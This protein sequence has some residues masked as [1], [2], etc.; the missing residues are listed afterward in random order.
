MFKHIFCM[1][2]LT[3]FSINA[4]AF[5]ITTFKSE[6]LDRN[7]RTHILVTGVGED[8]GNQ[9]Q[10]VAT[11]KAL[12]YL[13]NFPTDQIVLITPDE[14]DLD[15][16]PALANWGFKVQDTN[17]RSFDGGTLLDELMKFNAIASLDIFS[18]S[19]AQYGIHLDGKLH[20]FTNNTKGIDKLKSHF[21]SDAFTFLHGCNAGFNFAPMLASSWQIPVAGA[22]TSTNFHKLHENGSFY[23][24]EKEFKP[25]G[26]W[27]KSNNLS[28]DV[29]VTCSKGGCQRLKPD[30]QP[31]IGFWGEYHDGGLPFYKFFCKDI[32]E[33]KCLLGMANS[34]INFV[35]TENLKKES[36]LETFKK[37]AYDFLCPISSKSNVRAEC[38]RNLEASLTGGDATYNPFLQDQVDCDFTGCKVEI[39]CEKIPVFGV[40]KPGTCTLKNNAGMP[41]TTLVREYKAYIKAFSLL[42]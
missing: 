32:D 9:F 26:N 38:E 33:N 41:A 19:S 5:Y 13:Q 28:F 40:F 24:N 16:R 27:A 20:R 7:Q 8:L 21:T 10:E 39:T 2:L 1:S 34:L 3:M 23:L 18:H 12:K 17:K 6:N 15:T 25:E 22:M 42:K 35:G 4:N 11:A 14:K 29:P 31:Y 36:N 37:A 30:N